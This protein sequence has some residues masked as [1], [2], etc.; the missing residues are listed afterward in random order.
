M[1]ACTSSLEGSQFS[2]LQRSLSTAS[3]FTSRPESPASPSTSRE[4][5]RL[6]Q[7]SGIPFV[8]T[9]ASAASLATLSRE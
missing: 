1:T 5:G 4:E 8:L 2:L 9:R 7:F 6:S 3:F